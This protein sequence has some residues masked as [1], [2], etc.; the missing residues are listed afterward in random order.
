MLIT[1][2]VLVAPLLGL[3][4]DLIWFAIVMMINME[5]ALITP[6]VGLNLF[7]VGGLTRSI[8]VRVSQ[9]D[10]IRGI[11]PYFFLMLTFMIL[12]IFWPPAITW[13]PSLFN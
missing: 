1:L 5:I 11:V 4:V 10:V 6:P 13:F 8:N 9:A 2:P 12:C 7:V 3:Q